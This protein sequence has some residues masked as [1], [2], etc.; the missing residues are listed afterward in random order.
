MITI[1]SINLTEWQ[2]EVFK[3]F[4]ANPTNT[5]LVVKA[6]RQVGKS[7]CLQQLALYQSLN[8]K[9]HSV[10]I[11]SP[12]MPQS[13]RLFKELLDLLY[14][15]GAISKKNE[16]LL[17]IEF[18][19]GSKIY[20]KSAEQGDNLRG[21]NCNLLILDEAA[22]IEDDVFTLLQPA[23]DAKNADI[24]MF[25]TPMFEDGFFYEYYMKGL[26][27]MSNVIS[28]D[29]CDFDT[30]RFLSPEKLEQYRHQLPK[31]RFQT[32]YLGQFISA[33]ENGVFQNF[34]NCIY[35]YKPKQGEIM[36]AGI[37]WAADGQ[38]RTVVTTMTAGTCHMT[39]ILILENENANTAVKKIGDFLIANHVNE[40][41]VEKNSIGAVYRDLLAK[42]IGDLINIKVF[43]TTNDSKRR[44]IERLATAFQTGT[45]SIVKNDV[46]LSELTTY[47]VEKSGKQGSITYNAERGHHDDT[48]MSLAIC[49]HLASNANKNLAL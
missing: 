22:F 14:G 28:I 44:I 7:I 9:G 32:E 23:T 20:F 36:K 17:E 10:M 24:I 42:E 16:S 41:E 39:D 8:H 1:E 29:W 25:S 11:V 4:I 13:R 47:R 21:F 18:I 49:Y 12:T 37:D 19:N 30:S 2:E 35:P 31:L 46:L 26:T 38:D 6:K 43:Q 48:V 33:S 34:N 40:V 5:I 45:I 27:G 3:R 15:T